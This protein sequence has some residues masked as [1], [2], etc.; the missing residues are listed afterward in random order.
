MCASTKQEY[1][2]LLQI[3][4]LLIIVATLIGVAIGHWPWLRMN[5]ATIALTGATA[6]I[7]IGAI[8]LEEACATILT[9]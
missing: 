7:A 3:S 1:M 8:P 5:R 4:A 9:R 2:T 6:L